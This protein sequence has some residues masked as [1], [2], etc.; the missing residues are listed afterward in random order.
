MLQQAREQLTSLLNSENL[1]R[2]VTDNPAL[3]VQ[4][5][6]NWFDAY[7]LWEDGDDDFYKIWGEKRMLMRSI[8]DSD[9]VY[10]SL[11]AK[12]PTYA[13]W[14]EKGWASAKGES[15]KSI[16]IAGVGYNTGRD[17]LMKRTYPANF[18]APVG[19]NGIKKKY[20]EGLL[21]VSGT[22]LRPDIEI[23]KQTHVKPKHGDWIFFSPLS[24]EADQELLLFMKDKLKQLQTVLGKSPPGLNQ[25]INK[26]K[27]IC[28]EVTRLK[29]AFET[30][31][32]LG[33]VA[34]PNADDTYSKY[35]Y[36]VKSKVT[37]SKNNPDPQ[38]KSK[39]LFINDELAAM[40]RNNV[41]RYKSVVGYA[42]KNEVRISLRKHAN[43]K[44][45]IIASWTGPKDSDDGD[46]EVHTKI[47]SDWT[48]TKQKIANRH[49]AAFKG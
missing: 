47:G 8:G 43:P 21:D 35:K 9:S 20:A 6:N 38:L 15:A 26:Y 34:V 24:D 19:D 48:S 40:L 10:T 25:I 46:W 28:S 27:V 18:L 12:A 37:Y 3:V 31:M 41:K 17:G 45:P 22:L 13:A 5:M 33:F 42:V 1:L 32:A 30:D 39:A 7:K 44:W 49:P 4:V 2:F 16:T 29:L 11:Q 36:M 23:T 14:Q